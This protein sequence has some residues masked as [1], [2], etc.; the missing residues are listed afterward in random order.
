MRHGPP[1]AHLYLSSTVRSRPRLEIPSERQ[2]SALCREVV[3]TVHPSKES[4][5]GGIV[6]G[7]CKGIHGENNNVYMCMYVL[8]MPHSIFA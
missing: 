6:A 2:H 4:S 7:N 8:S 1:Y 5:E 3:V